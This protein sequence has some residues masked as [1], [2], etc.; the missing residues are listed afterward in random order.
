M[1][2]MV[3]VLGLTATSHLRL[4][5][6]PLLRASGEAMVQKYQSPVRVYKY[7]FELVMAVSASPSLGSGCGCRGAAVGE[8]QGPSE[9]EGDGAVQQERAS[10]QAEAPLLIPGP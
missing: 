7:P 3:G 8:E 2:A 9:E 1:R 4:L 6:P 10:V 5:P